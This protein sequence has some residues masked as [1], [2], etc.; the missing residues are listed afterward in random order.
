MYATVVDCKDLRSRGNLGTK[1][2]TLN[3]DFDGLIDLA[4]TTYVSFESF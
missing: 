2:Y 1:S 3:A 4:G